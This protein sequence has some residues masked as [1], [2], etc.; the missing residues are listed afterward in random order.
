MKKIS[1]L[2]SRVGVGICDQDLPEQAKDT[3]AVGW[4]TAICQSL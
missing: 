3:H 2:A 4:M 1:L